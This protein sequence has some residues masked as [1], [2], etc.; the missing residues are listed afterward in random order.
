MLVL[1]FTTPIGPALI[2]KIANASL[3]NLEIKGFSGTFLSQLTINQLTWSDPSLNIEVEGVKLKEPRFDT[4]NNRFYSP[5]ANIDRFVIRLPKSDDSPS[6]KITSLPNFSLP[7]HLK[8]DSLALKSFEIIRENKTLFEIKNIVLTRADIEKGNLT[9][10]T[11]KAEPII[12]GSPLKVALNNVAMG[13]DQPHNITAK[14]TI[15]Y[16]QPQ[17]GKLVSDINLSGT[18]TAYRFKLNAALDNQHAGSQNIQLEGSGDYDQVQLSN[19]NTKSADGNIKGKAKIKW[20]PEITW[21]FDGKVQQIKIAKY[22]PDWPAEFDATL[23]YHGEYKN[24][25]I[26][27]K[28]NVKSLS[29]LLQN[30][31]ITAS[32]QLQHVDQDLQVDNVLAQLGNNKVKVNGKASAPFD[33]S[34]D[35][36]ASELGQLLPDLSGKLIASG[37]L[38]G[39]LDHPI[40][41]AKAD[42]KKIK[43][44]TYSLDS[45][46]LVAQTKQGI[47]S[48]QG[49]LNNLDIDQQNIRHA[50]LDA[51]GK[52]DNHRFTLNLTHSEAKVQ[53]QAQGGWID[54]QWK[55]MVKKLQLDTKQVAKWTLQKPVLITASKDSV[56]SSQF[57][58]SNHVASS[59]ST[60]NWSTTKGVNFE[61]KLNRTPLA[62]LNPWLPKGLQLKGQANGRYKVHHINGKAAGEV[63]IQLPASVVLYGTGK[64][65]QPLEYKSVTLNAIINGNNITAKMRMI[66]KNKGGLTADANIKLSKHGG[67]PKINVSGRLTRI[68]LFMAKPWLP[69]TLQLKGSAN[70]HYKVNLIGKAMGEVSLQ[71]PASVVLYGVGKNKQQIAYKSVTLKAIINDNNITAKTRLI[72]KNKGELTADANITLSK[73]GA[74]PK[75]N[76]AG[77][78]T[79]LP[80]S[81]AKPWLPKTLH[82]KG[83]ANGRYKVQLIGKKVAG[84]ATLNLPASTLLIGEGKD[85]QQIDYKFLKLNAS[86]N[87]K[88]I[89]ANTRLLLNNNGELNAD[90]N[91][92]LAKHGNHHQISAKG[93]ISR[94]PLLTAQSWLPENVKLKGS[95][96]GSFKLTQQKGKTVG[97]IAI[98]I[99]NNS[100]TYSDVDGNKTTFD[101][102]NASVTMNIN[103]KIILSNAKIQLKNRGNLAAEAKITL[104]ANSNAH[105]IQ[106]KATADVPNI[107]W[108][109]SFIPH[110][111]NLAGRISSHIAFN[112]RLFSPKIKGKIVLEQAS[113]KL[114]EVGTKL[115]N[116]NISINAN[117]ANKAIINGSLHSG[118]GQAK[119]SGYLSLKDL[120]Q[121]KGEMKIVGSNLQFINTYEARAVMDP[122]ISIKISPK[123][124]DILGRIHIPNAQ[125]TLNAIPVST[126]SESEDVIVIGEKKPDG[127]YSALKIRPKLTVSLGNNVKFKGFGFDTKLEGMIN[128][129]HNRQSI[130]T[131]GTVKIMEGRYEAYGQNL[132]LNNG[133]LVFNGP[134]SVIG[135][136]VK[137]I[138]TIDDIVAG[139]HLTGTLLSPKTKLFSTPA[140]S[141]SNILSYLLTGHSLDDITGSQTALLMQAVRSL[142]IVNGDGLLRNIGN[143]LGLDDLRFVAKDDLKKSELRLGKK[144]GSRTYVRYIVGLFDSMQKIAIE[145]KVNKYLNLEAQAGADAQSIDLIY[146][147]ETN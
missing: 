97:N 99:P 71:L 128:V 3:Q 139:I 82:L 89:T 124:V 38:K 52:I 79:R 137:A 27:G 64:N 130:T 45:A 16:Q 23:K 88:K 30:K 122:N 65:K 145:Y 39:T 112:G 62:L 85:K 60:V 48:L 98:Q 42:A 59:C 133:R 40:L 68:P 46:H 146:K 47:Y 74:D 113:I 9:V 136:D 34:W 19:I 25:S 15:N 69:E 80:L 33:L 75:I 120:R 126:I 37:T 93:K 61:G 144:L 111:S 44:H 12:I 29:G 141:E 70:G 104:G 118:A 115:H 132:A 66:L 56:K 109:Q 5:S 110:S 140:F 143:S 105:R 14:G 123:T 81:I 131:Q 31:K 108:I 50:T 13:M 72:L 116:I 102:H 92:T 147:V 22:V 125:I 36:N 32:G 1:I 77:K 26:Q 135:I 24:D 67:N 11:L 119:I 49:N 35:I 134:P 103:D 63:S 21:L 121:L 95:V 54:Q 43:Y 18:L 76:V 57:C 51:S 107:R 83:N 129:S 7:I 94:L 86:I 117:N 20:K 138:R 87:G 2:G 90:A 127:N 41:N 6:E 101:Y 58:F 91:I 106:G 53:L 73:G 100:L 84:E 10:S 28:L 8:M 114:L 142:N 96:N 4:K 78:L 17:V 55:G